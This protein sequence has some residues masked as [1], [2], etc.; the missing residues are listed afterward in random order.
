MNELNKLKREE[1]LRALANLR[2]L[3]RR[4]AKRGTPCNDYLLMSFKIVREK[5]KYLFRAFYNSP[6]G[7]SGLPLHPRPQV[8]KLL[9]A[10]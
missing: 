2:R 9:S 3:L 4:P 7:K 6:D 1:L 10:H 8:E 5:L